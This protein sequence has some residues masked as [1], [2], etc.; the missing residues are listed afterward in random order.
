MEAEA[1][2]LT[3]NSLMLIWNVRKS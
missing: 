3:L 2:A 1:D